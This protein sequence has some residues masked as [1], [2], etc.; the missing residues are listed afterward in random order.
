MSVS[1]Q[2]TR[3]Q[4]ESHK[5][6][7]LIF[8][9][10]GTWNSAALGR[11][12]D[13]TNLYKINLSLKSYDRHSNPQIVFYVP[14]PGNRG[15]IDKNIGGAFASG[16]DQIIKEA[17]VNLS[18]NYAKGDKIYFFG[19]SRGAIVAR[20]LTG[21]ISKCGLLKSRHIDHLWVVWNHFIDQTVGIDS[22]QR[23]QNG[24]DPYIHDQPKIQML[25]LFDTVLGRNYRKSDRFAQ[26]RF[27][28]NKLDVSVRN[29]VQLLSID[30]NRRKFT[31]L[32]WDGLYPHQNVE[33]IWMPGVHGDIG[34]AGDDNFLSDV[35]LLTMFD[36]IQFYTRLHLDRNYIAQI[37]RR[38]DFYRSIAVSNERLAPY[39]RVLRHKARDGS[40]GVRQFHH[41]LLPLIANKKIVLRGIYMPYD[42]KGIEDFTRLNPAPTRYDGYYREQVRRL[43]NEMRGRGW[44]IFGRR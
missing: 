13:L 29:A 12:Q 33:Q 32:V 15:W 31:P 35:A 10:D 11:P 8:L 41:P 17:Y 5:N 34:G 38:L 37:E 6:K 2:K 36:R 30:D 21:L 16:I 42:R 43:D 14:G 23:K 3:Q 24:I 25:G 20:A 28:N 4:V 40:A 18:S 27:D 9:F 39:M 22:Y 1:I 26:V 44:F 7:H 19:F